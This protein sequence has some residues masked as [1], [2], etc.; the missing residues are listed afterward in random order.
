M[1][2]IAQMSER[3][4]DFVG[5]SLKVL[6]GF[7]KEVRTA[8]GHA[9]D[10]AQRG[11][12]APYAKPMKGIGSGVFEIVDDFDGNTYRAVYAVKIGDCLYVLH[13]FQKKSKSGSKT[14][15]AEIE[16]VKDRVKKL[17]AMLGMAG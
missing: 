14:P 13:A 6:K 10:A 11:G 8:I 5:D 2:I 3:R 17:K 15:L 4:C 12:K 7:P 1:G 9:L 16:L